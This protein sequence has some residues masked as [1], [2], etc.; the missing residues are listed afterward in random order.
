MANEYYND[1]DATER[2]AEWQ[3]RTIVIPLYAYTDLLLETA[4]LKHQL[5][6][7]TNRWATNNTRIRELENKLAL[8]VDEWSRVEE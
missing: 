2:P 1:F 5:T 8:Q 4:D 3:A 6:D 7:M